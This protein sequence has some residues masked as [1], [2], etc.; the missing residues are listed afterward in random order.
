MLNKA[1]IIGNLGKDPET[2]FTPSGVQ[3]TKFSVATSKKWKNKDGKQQE[4]TQWHRIV[5][6]NKLAKIAADYLHQGSKVY[7][8]GEIRTNKWQDKD[9][10]DRYT[11][12]I[13]ANEIKMLSKE[14]AEDNSPIMR[15]IVKQ[16]RSHPDRYAPT[17]QDSEEPDIDDDIPF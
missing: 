5:C 8:E 3:V 14:I 13:F 16:N 4:D 17:E 12:E 10:N 7:V 1:M 15:E 11:T 6:F 9:G 2:S